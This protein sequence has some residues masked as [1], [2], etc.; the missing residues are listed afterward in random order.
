VDLDLLDKMMCYLQGDQTYNFV[1][2]ETSSNVQLYMKMKEKYPVMTN[3]LVNLVQ[4]DG[5]IEKP[6]CRFITTMIRHTKNVY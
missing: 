6:I 1:Q 3:I 2:A 5:K 4:K